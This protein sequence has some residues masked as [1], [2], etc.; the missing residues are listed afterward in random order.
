MNDYDDAVTTE[1]QLE[2]GGSY[3][4]KYSAGN[5]TIG[6]GKSFQAPEIATAVTT[7]ST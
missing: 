5:I 1:Q 7:G 6:Y 2:E 3:A 4:A